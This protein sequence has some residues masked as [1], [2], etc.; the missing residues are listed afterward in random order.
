M[1][2]FV[3]LIM[4]TKFGDNITLSNINYVKS[5]FVYLFTIII[6]F[7]HR[8]GTCYSEFVKS[9]YTSSTLFTGI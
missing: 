3:L 2:V 6:H 5:L 8:F 7:S 1:F 9:R 4:S